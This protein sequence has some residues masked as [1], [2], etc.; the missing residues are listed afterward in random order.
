MFKV[1]KKQ[2]VNFQCK[3]KR[4]PNWCFK[5]NQGSVVTQGD[6]DDCEGER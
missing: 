6:T 2:N 1:F 4:Q 5:V 3:K